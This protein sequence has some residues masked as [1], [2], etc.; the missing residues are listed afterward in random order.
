[1]QVIGHTLCWH[2]Q[3]PA[4]LFQDENGKPLPREAALANLKS[5]VHGVVGHFKGK[6]RGWDVVNEAISDG[7]G[8]MLRDTP[9]RRAIGDDYVVKA[10]QFAHE[11]DRD[12]E[13]Y[14]NDY[15]IEH[16]P[17]RD[18]AI[19]LIRQIKAAGARIDA[20]GI[21]GHWMLDFPSVAEIERGLNAWSREGVK[22][23]ISEMDVDVLPRSKPGGANLDALEAEG[24]D[25]YRSGLPDTV[26]RKLAERYEQ[27]FS[28][29]VKTPQVTRITLWGTTDG[30]SW[31]N[32][33]PVRG[34]TNYP[35]LFDR[36][37]HPKPAFDAVVRSLQH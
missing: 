20:V 21:Q 18:R 1:M 26:Q 30:H 14:Y 19:E 23:M 16:G 10:F 25:P 31:L 11:A 4:W 35:L 2:Q 36:S 8:G 7:P 28:L 9:A 24:L 6:I 17:K 5:H 15:N 34:R 37:Y 22:L 27:L 32:N 12:V 13:L 33:F 29:L 3:S